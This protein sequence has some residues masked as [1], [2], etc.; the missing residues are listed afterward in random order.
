LPPQ[1]LFAIGVL[2]FYFLE[3]NLVRQDPGFSLALFVSLAPAQASVR[4]GINDYIPERFDSWAIAVADFPAFGNWFPDPV[5][6][7]VSV[8]LTPFP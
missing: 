8:S 1:S 7:S 2:R 3:A 5:S 6:V 4:F